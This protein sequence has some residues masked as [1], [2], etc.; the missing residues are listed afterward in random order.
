M[1]ST[2]SGIYKC[3]NPGNGQ[4]KCNWLK[5][6]PNLVLLMIDADQKSESNLVQRNQREIQYIKRKGEKLKS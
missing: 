6:T 3:N 4:G 5:H 2:T 1:K